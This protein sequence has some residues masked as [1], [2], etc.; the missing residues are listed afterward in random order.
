MPPAHRGLSQSLLLQQT[1]RELRLCIC[2]RQNCY[3]SLL[4]NLRLCQG[5]GFCGE[6]S[7]LNP[8]T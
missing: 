5:S 3:A 4:Q 7:I 2:L 6:V 1:Q 8:T